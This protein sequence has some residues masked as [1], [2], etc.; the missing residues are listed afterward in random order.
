MVNIFEIK[1]LTEKYIVVIITITFETKV[2]ERRF[3]L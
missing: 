2:T 3:S 1:V